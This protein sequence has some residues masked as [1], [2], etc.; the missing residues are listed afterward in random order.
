[1][2]D[3]SVP[4]IQVVTGAI[5]SPA[6]S[7]VCDVD[8]TSQKPNFKIMSDSCSGV[9][10]APQQS[11]AVAVTFEPQP[12]TPLTPALDYFLELSTLECTS[13]TTSNC[14]IDSGRF[15]VELKA[16]TPSPLRMSPGAGLDF[17]N[18]PVGQTSAPLT[19]TLFNDPADPN[20]QTITFTGNIVK[21]DYVETDNCG[22]S[23][24]PGSSCTLSVTFRPKV[25]G[26]AQ[27]SIT[28]TYTVGQTQT[29]YLRGT[30]Q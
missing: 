26:F 1:V 5:G 3:G 12:A 17:G 18:Q 13:T 11:C 4:G 20:A 14:E 21:G 7:Y 25:V 28:I 6:I 24:A 27:G 2:T 9:S 19:I 22:T 8:Q 16:N 30:G 10:L 15:P 29:V 23:L